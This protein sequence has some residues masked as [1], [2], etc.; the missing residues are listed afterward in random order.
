MSTIPDRNLVDLQKNTALAFRYFL[1]LAYNGEKYHGWQI[2]ENAPTIQQTLEEALT[3][4]LKEPIRITGAGRTDAG[5]HASE[6]YAHFDLETSLS[7]KMIISLIFKLNRYLP[8]D[9]AIYDL[10]PVPEKAHARF[11][12]V[13]RTY[14][15]HILRHKDPFRQDFAFTC[16]FKLNIESMNEAASILFQYEDFTSFAKS[17]TQVKTN[18]CKLMKAEWE[19]SEGGLVFSIKADRF[20][21]NMV[22]AIVGTLIDVGRERIKAS[23]MHQIIQNKDRSL[24]GYSVPAKGLFLQSIEYPEVVLSYQKDMARDW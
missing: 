2:Q 18:I 19:E 15:Y 6:F 22:R 1:K 11:S 4:I 17:N 24:A 23:D 13:S 5:V 14:Q 16:F 7:T 12:A 10:F 20:L 3:R 8:N 9:I 21:R